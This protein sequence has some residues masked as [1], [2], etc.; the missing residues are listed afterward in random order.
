M[1]AEGE[2]EDG[3]FH[4]DMMGFPPP[5]RRSQ[6]LAAAGGTDFLGLPQLS[7][8]SLLMNCRTPNSDN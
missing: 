8:Q 4:V 2:L 1:L 5:E 6:S 7:A 3:V